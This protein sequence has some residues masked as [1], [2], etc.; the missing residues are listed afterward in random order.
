MPE[1][2]LP[3]VDDVTPEPHRAADPAE[4]RSSRNSILMF[5]LL[6]IVGFMSFTAILAV[7]GLVVFL[8]FGPGEEKQPS[9][10]VSSPAQEIARTKQAE[11]MDAF[12]FRNDEL[13]IVRE[14][15]QAQLHLTKRIE[16][17][18][19][20]LRG[21]IAAWQDATMP[22]LTNDKGKAIAAHARSLEEFHALYQEE[23]PERDAPD[24]FE[25]R[26][27]PF[28][29]H[30]QTASD[31]EDARHYRPTEEFVTNLETLAADVR[32]ATTAYRRQNRL[33]ETLVLRTP[34]P[35]SSD[36]IPTLETAIARLENDRK[37]EDLQKT[38][39][40]LEERREENRKKVAAAT[41]E[42]E[43]KIADA[44]A[45]ALKQLG[46]LQAQKITAA[47]EAEIAGFQAK[48]AKELREAKFQ[49]ALPE[50]RTYLAPFLVDSLY[51]PASGSSRQTTEKKPI[52]WSKL[53]A[54][55]ALNETQQGVSKLYMTILTAPDRARHGWPAYQG[56]SSTEHILRAQ[57]L[58][59]EFG[60]MLVDKKMLSP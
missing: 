11:T 23:L 39:A 2:T 57:K 16:E 42:K 44:E 1:P 31:V 59:I 10:P 53:T 9:V 12:N 41:A 3:E 25:A 21:E 60:D 22:L 47:V 20:K 51:Q 18:I 58:L 48:Q 49:A 40:E 27:R 46:E 56:G 28:V 30:L 54:S 43:T 26:L 33:L 36:E 35:D 4:A 19:Q 50:I 45:D 34:K 24:S 37:V 52:S 17:N 13:A 29:D 14:R 6:L 5:G 8:Q 7:I 32:D 15:I 55:G 38:A